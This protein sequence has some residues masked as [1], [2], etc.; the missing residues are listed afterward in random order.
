MD[1]NIFSQNNPN[2]FQ[3][4][5]QPP[6]KEHINTSMADSERIS[7]SSF[8][9]KQTTQSEVVNLPGKN[10]A[11]NQ[12]QQSIA[13]NKQISNVFAK[14]LKD[15]TSKEVSSGLK[16]PSNSSLFWYM[17]LLKWEKARQKRR[18]L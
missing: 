11:D 6:E 15:L 9:E 8:Q 1:Q 4:A 2:S 13:D 5:F 18:K 12:L 17:M 7:N 3:G 10:I 14:E 16:K